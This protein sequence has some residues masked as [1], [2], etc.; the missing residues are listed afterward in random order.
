VALDVEIDISVGEDV[1]LAGYYAHQNDTSKSR[2]R[3]VNARGAVLSL[4]F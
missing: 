4:Y 1:E 2:N 3:Q